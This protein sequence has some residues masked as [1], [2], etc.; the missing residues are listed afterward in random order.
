MNGMIPPSPLVPRLS[1]ANYW[2]Q[3]LQDQPLSYPGL[4]GSLTPQHIPTGYNVDRY[5]LC[6]GT[7]AATFQR[8]KQAIRDWQM[9]PSGWTRILPQPVPIASGEMVTVNF[10]LLGLWWTCVCRIVQAIDT[11]QQ[12]GFAYGT[13]AQHV[14]RGE[15]LFQVEWRDNDEVWY[16]ILAFSRPQWWPVWLAYPYARLK[17]RQFGRQSCASMLRATQGAD[18]GSQLDTFAARHHVQL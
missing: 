9:F 1:H 5:E 16:H 2:V 3:R 11:P 13:L 8:A 17:Q 10:R 14:E 6:L 15:E 18:P 12:F 7:G 4:Y